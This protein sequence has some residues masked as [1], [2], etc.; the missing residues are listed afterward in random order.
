VPEG[1]GRVGEQRGELR[2]PAEERGVVD[3]DAAFGE[4]L[5]DVPVGQPEPADTNA[6]PA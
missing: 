5:L 4:Q 6:R 1:P 3:V 2:H